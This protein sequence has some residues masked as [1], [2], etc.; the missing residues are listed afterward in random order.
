VEGNFSDSL[1]F[2]KVYQ[3]TAATTFDRNFF[4]TTLA[5]IGC[6]IVRHLGL[7]IEHLRRHSTTLMYSGEGGRYSQQ[8]W[9]STASGFGTTPTLIPP[10]YSQTKR[11][12]IVST[13]TSTRP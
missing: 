10:K 4:S 13:T 3:L 9:R 12:A 8:F 11:L 1:K 7:P 6:K 5:A 2:V